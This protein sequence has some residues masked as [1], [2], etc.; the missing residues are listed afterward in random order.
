V[1]KQSDGSTKVTKVEGGGLSPGSNA[2]TITV[3]ADPIKDRIIVLILEKFE[4]E[5]AA[6][7]RINGKGGEDDPDVYLAEELASCFKKDAGQLRYIKEK[8]I[9]YFKAHP[10]ELREKIE[11][12][13]TKKT[14]FDKIAA[15]FKSK[16]DVA[17]TKVSSDDQEASRNATCEALVDDIAPLVSF[18]EKV[19]PLVS[20]EDYKSALKKI[21]AI[22][23]FFKTCH[24]EGWE[25]YNGEGIVPYC[26]WR[27]QNVSSSLYYSNA[28][29]PF[30]SGLIDGAYIEAKG[31]YHLPDVVR[32]ITKLPSKLVY[33]YTLA[34]WECSPEKLIASVKEYEYVIEQLATM[35]EEGGLWNWVKEQWH[36]YEG[37]KEDI[38]KYFKDCRDAE[39]LRETITDLYE[40]VTSW[41]EIKTLS[42]QVYSRL[43]DYWNTLSSTN[44]IGRYQQGR[45]IIPAATLILPFGA[46]IAS[47]AEKL[48]DALKLLRAASEENWKKFIDGLGGLL[49]KRAG[50]TFDAAKF[51]QWIRNISTRD[52]AGAVGS[53][54][55]V[56]QERVAGLL[57]YEIKGGDNV[58]IWA[59]GVDAATGKVI[60]AKYISNPGASP[61]VEG[62]SCYPPVRQKIVEQVTDEFNRYSKI[63]KD[64]QT[65]LIELE[66][67]IS[68]VQAKPFFEKLL[69]D[70]DIPGRVI[71]KP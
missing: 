7:L 8:T 70:F 56:Y 10:A 68:D 48:K 60:E 6:W 37:Q 31:L 55:R 44:N 65:P 67:T 1:Q 39:D 46:G 54:P 64:P 63:I 2:S 52:P 32:D 57:E 29:L 62:S 5:I 38:E 17:W 12:N 47:K 28:D 27:D 53:G 58:K 59:D 15:L 18:Y 40:L 34:Y 16:D 45:I 22:Y 66:V 41:E 71:V 25:S 61:F 13:Q 11:S 49:A 19:K 4:E 33:A 26:F 9:P 24:N 3:Q 35:E 14:L 42:Q 23:E 69:K 36:D 43:G 20:N 51:Q 21:K 30:T 50:K